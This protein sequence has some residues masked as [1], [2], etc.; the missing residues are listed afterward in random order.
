MSDIE[1]TT[2]QKVRM[3]KEWSD[4]Q[5]VFEIVSWN[6]SENKGRIEDA[7]GRGWNVRGSQIVLVE[8]VDDGWGNDEEEDMEE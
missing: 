7:D 2:G 8:D 5:E 1:F 3:S 4:S 6:D